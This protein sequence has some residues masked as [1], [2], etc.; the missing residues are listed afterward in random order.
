MLKLRVPSV[1]KIRPELSEVDLITG[2]FSGRASVYFYYHYPILTIVI[3]G[4][5]AFIIVYINL[6][7]FRIN[8]LSQYRFKPRIKT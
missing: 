6:Y 7:W 4:L 5:S 3:T 2:I 1:L 8:Y